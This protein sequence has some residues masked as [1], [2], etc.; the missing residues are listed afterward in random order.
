MVPMPPLMKAL[1]AAKGRQ[2][3]AVSEALAS[4]PEA[5]QLP[6]FDHAVEPPLCC[7]VRL[8]CEKDVFEVLIKYGADV[9]AADK[10][11]RT[12]LSLL[13][14]SYA[15][16][17]S[18]AQAWLQPIHQRS[19][20]A[21]DTRQEDCQQYTLTVATELLEAGADPL[22]AVRMDNGKVSCL[23][24]TRSVNNAP[25]FQLLQANY[26]RLR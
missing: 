15:R 26:R 17:P 18:L 6:F 22:D 5:A 13:C 12:P 2:V 16:L 21:F 4:D 11:G 23:E 9:N 7:A 24:Y 19:G 25:L 8:G 3:V 14:Y 1:H 10:Y 20:P